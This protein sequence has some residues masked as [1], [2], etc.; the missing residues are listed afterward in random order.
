MFEHT[1]S[2]YFPFRMMLNLMTRLTS[3]LGPDMNRETV[4]N[5]ERAGF[6]VSTC[7]EYLS[8]CCKNDRSQGSSCMKSEGRA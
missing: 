1:G 8:R 5:V 4:H 3:R 2:H 7:D 6:T